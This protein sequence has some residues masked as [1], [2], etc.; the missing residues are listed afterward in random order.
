MS[1]KWLNVRGGNDNSSLRYGSADF[2]LQIN[3]R[4]I[5]KI[6][7]KY[8]RYVLPVNKNIWIFFAGHIQDNSKSSEHTWEIS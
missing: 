6:Q 4:N 8:V 2:C 7:L 1:L 5:M 3:S